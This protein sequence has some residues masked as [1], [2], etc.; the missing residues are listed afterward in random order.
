MHNLR[1]FQIN[2][3]LQQYWKSYILCCTTLAATCVVV[4]SRLQ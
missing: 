1:E 3:V 4:P 2:G